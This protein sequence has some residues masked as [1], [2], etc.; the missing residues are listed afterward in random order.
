MESKK[1]A[2]LL[3]FLSTLFQHQQQHQQQ[4]QQRVPWCAQMCCVH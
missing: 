3:A 4:Q 1:P 2:R